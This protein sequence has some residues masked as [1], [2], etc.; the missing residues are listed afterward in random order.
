MFAV[1]SEWNS[2][3]AVVVSLL[4]ILVAYL[5]SRSDLKKSDAKI[6]AR[7]DI[8]DEAEGITTTNRPDPP[9]PKSWDWE[10]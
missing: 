9:Q 2:L 6:N 7:I 4:W 8:H 5:Q 3:L 10:E 1:S